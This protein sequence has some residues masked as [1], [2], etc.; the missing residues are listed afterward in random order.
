MI[1][2]LCYICADQGKQSTATTICNELK[3]PVCA[4][5]AHYC[6]EE[7]HGTSPLQQREEN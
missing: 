1:L 6:V 5:H 2:D 7:G 3:K 4:D